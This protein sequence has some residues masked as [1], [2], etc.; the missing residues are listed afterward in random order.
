M[1]KHYFS[2]H[3][4]LLYFKVHSAVLRALTLNGK[5]STDLGNRILSK[6]AVINAILSSKTEDQIDST[7]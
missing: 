5:I 7:F 4:W 2:Y 3:S 6:G 1:K